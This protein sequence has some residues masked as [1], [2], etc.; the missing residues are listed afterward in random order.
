MSYSCHRFLST[1]SMFFSHKPCLVGFRNSGCEHK[2]CHSREIPGPPGPSDDPCPIRAQSVP[3]PCLPAFLFRQI[4]E[5]SNYSQSFL[6]KND[7]LG[8]VLFRRLFFRSYFRT[9][10]NSSQKA[11]YSSRNKSQMAPNE[12]VFFMKNW[13]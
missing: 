4:L 11:V 13:D 12:K 8:F 9:I 3:D 7:V 10:L 6:M 2:G 1:S 5:Q